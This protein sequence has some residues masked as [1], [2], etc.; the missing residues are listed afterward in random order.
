[1]KGCLW[2]AA[3]KLEHKKST[4][5]V[6]SFHS[7]LRWSGLFTMKKTSLGRDYQFAQQSVI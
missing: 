3:L 1:M 2:K 4:H 7:I 6:V 5:R